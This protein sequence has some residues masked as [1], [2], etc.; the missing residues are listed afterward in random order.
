MKRIYLILTAVV[1]MFTT[2]SFAQAP[3][4]NWFRAAHAGFWSNEHIDYYHNVES[5]VVRKYDVKDHFGELVKYGE[6]YV[7]TYAFDERG[8]LVRNSTI[9]EG[10]P[11]DVITYKYDQ[12]G[13]LIV[14]KWYES[15]GKMQ[16]TY[17]YQYDSKGRMVEGCCYDSAGVLSFGSVFV[18]DD[19]NGRVTREDYYP[20]GEQV[21]LSG[22]FV[23]QYDS[24]GNLQESNY[25]ESNG[26]L[27]FSTIYR[28]NSEGKLA[29]KIHYK[30]DG[31]VDE[32]E[33][34]EY[35]EAGN[36]T[37]FYCYDGKAVLKEKYVYKYDSRGNQV[38]C[39]AYKTASLIPLDY[40]EIEIVYKE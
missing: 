24:E 8:R 13:R 3:A 33:F 9:L 39:I 16:E 4:C 35:D 20:S 5:V 25:F 15:T 36:M 14:S 23:K 30:P 29:E 32:R 27:L 2:A 19:D 18:H 40:V 28:Y 1:T 26:D 10:I 22:R 37:A 31:T 6:P 38:E 12:E 7:A 21:E 34:F 11:S 17:L